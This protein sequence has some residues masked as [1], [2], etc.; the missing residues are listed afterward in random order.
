M[1]ARLRKKKLIERQSNDKNDSSE[2][3]PVKAAAVEKVKIEPDSNWKRVAPKIRSKVITIPQELS[4]KE[5]KK[6][7]KEKRREARAKGE[8]EPNFYSEDRSK[9]GDKRKRLNGPAIPVIRDLV[10][11]ERKQTLQDEKEK[12]R[13][14][15]LEKVS[16]EE[17]SRY[18][19]LDCEMVGV[20]VDGKESALARVSITDWDG[21]IIYDKFVQVP[22]RVTDFRT[23]VS[24]VRAKDIKNK[25]AISPK[26]CRN[27]VGELLIGKILVGHSLK[28]DLR[29]LLL[30]HPRH[31]IRDTANYKHYMKARGKNGGKLR[32]RKLKELAK[33]FLNIEIQ[34]D[35]EAHSSVDDARAAMELYKVQRSAWEKSLSIK[36]RK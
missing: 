11:I 36:R 27:V 35:G 34:I 4:S 32:P 31:D 25:D 33:E 22:Y 12:K 2:G 3:N 28:N 1:K 5:I 8:A 16:K 21:N 24:G 7:R 20:G 15:E 10:E 18:L 19:A 17:R 26:E 13:N 9:V 6:F 30:T 14:D 23:W 29:A